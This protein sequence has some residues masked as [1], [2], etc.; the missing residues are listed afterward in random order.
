M[1]PRP[2]TKLSYSRLQTFLSCPKK[3]FYNYVE[4]LQ[5]GFAAPLILGSLFHEVL[6]KFYKGEDVTP[7]IDTYKAYVNDGDLDTP[8]DLFDNVL[9]E[10]KLHYKEQ[11]MKEKPLG[12]ELKL[13][14]DWDAG[15]EVT[16]IIDK[17][18]ETD[19]GII[20]IRD[21][22]TT[23][24]SLKY[25]DESLRYNTQQLLYVALTEHAMNIDIDAIEIDEIRLA[26]LVPVPINKNGK[27]TTAMN[28]LGLV[29]HEAYY[30]KLCELGL[31]TNPE[32]QGVLT[33]LE[34]RGHPLF[35]RTTVQLVDRVI[36]KENL[37][38]VHAGYN[39]MKG[40]NDAHLYP[41][42]RGRMCSY[43]RYNDICKLD[44]HQPA[45]IDRQLLIE[46]HMK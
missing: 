6:E 1:K 45:D 18:V 12:I 14:Q 35:R 29:T 2:M 13:V 38:S 33:E 27:P 26:N 20:K 15:D 25:T 22:K 34:K 41:R 8:L 46:R 40:A 43:C 37:L 5:G 23:S 21:Y 10:Y 17:L 42:N 7:V 4:G 39:L 9:K 44:F 32:Y 16:G 3:Y 24:G 11:D 31:D 30:N 36:I 28:R 19:E